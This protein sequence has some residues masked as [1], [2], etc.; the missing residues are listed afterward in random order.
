MKF[1]TCKEI[2]LAISSY[3]DPRRNTIV[4]NVWWGMGFDHECDLLVL[5]KSGFAYE[6][7]IKISRS[8]LRADLRK[9]NGHESKYIKKLYF[10]MPDKMETCVD[11]VPGRAGILLVQQTGGVRKIREAKQ[12]SEAKPFPVEKQLKLA[13]LGTM[14]IWT[15]KREL[16]RKANATQTPT[17]I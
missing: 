4:P 1:E 16:L 15:L 9:R 10:A 11:L 5:T 13:Q 3:F 12:V 7:E 14:R 2:E 17:T 6:V 8:D